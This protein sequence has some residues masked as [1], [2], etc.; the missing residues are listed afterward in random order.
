MSKIYLAI[1]FDHELSLGGV[2]SSYAA[3]L[4]DPT[5]AILNEATAL[6]IPVTLFTDVLSCLKFEEWREI[7][8][9][10]PYKDKIREAIDSGHD[11]QLHLHPHWIETVFRNKKFIPSRK[12]SLDFFK[13]AP[14]PN[15]IF[16]I[17]ES[18]TSFINELCQQAD[19]TYRCI[20]YRAGG[21]NLAPSTHKIL[22]ALWDNGI[23]IDSSIAKGYKFKSTVNTVDY[24]DM[25]DAANWHIPIQGDL[26]KVATSGMFEVPLVSVPRN[27][28]NNI[29]ALIKRLTRPSLRPPETGVP[30][31]DLDSNIFDKLSRLFP[32]SRWMLSFDLYYM[33]SENLMNMLRK[34]V[35]AHKTQDVII[36]S[37]ISHP[38]AMGPSNIKLM[39]DFV[40]KAYLEYGDD[41]EFC[42]FSDIQ[43]LR[44]FS[45][46]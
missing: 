26:N 29:P 22:R 35:R 8:Y 34:Y 39:S 21:L 42:R 13:D 3:N 33:S 2:H 27:P 44:I 40:Q 9:S 17:V 15:D 20:A 1:S 31:Y 19:S 11:V 46:T 5:R 43:K 23:R 25:P 6:G 24:T 18:G 37:A 45:S 41:I 7:D 16:G 30:L 32:F 14:Y 12:Y 36:A 10:E 38:K 28:V 4:F